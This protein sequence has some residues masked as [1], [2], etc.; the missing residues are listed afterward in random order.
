MRQG[1]VAGCG[2]PRRRRA[3]VAACA[4]AP[5]LPPAPAPSFYTTDFDEVD[6]I[7]NLKKNPNLPM[8]ELDAMLEEFRK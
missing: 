3:A 7:F 5:P 4:H 2:R 8:E 1:F 6:E